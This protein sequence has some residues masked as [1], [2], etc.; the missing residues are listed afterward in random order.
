MSTRTW[1]IAVVSMLVAV[2]GFAGWFWFLREDSPQPSPILPVLEDYAQLRDRLAETAAMLP[3]EKT[4]GSTCRASAPLD[5]ALDY[6]Y[7]DPVIADAP[8]GNAA[9]MMEPSLTDPDLDIEPI[10]NFEF[11]SGL[12]YPLRLTGPHG[13]LGDEGFGAPGWNS[14]D[15]DS[16]EQS[17]RAT[18]EYGLAVRYLVVLRVT[19]Y[20]EPLTPVQGPDGSTLGWETAVTVDGFVVDLQTPKLLCSFNFHQDHLANAIPY[21]AGRGAAQSPFEVMYE[22]LQDRASCRF[23]EQLRALPGAIVTDSSG[24]C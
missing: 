11:T 18:M 4:E 20:V 5:P 3:S 2:L 12:L 9:V 8:Q 1:D 21:M 23:I 7:P 22:T 14:E 17:M 6:S 24:Y 16:S 19:D 13:P 15:P 10:E